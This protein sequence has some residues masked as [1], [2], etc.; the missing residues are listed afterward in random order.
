MSAPISRVVMPQLVV[1]AYSD[2]A[3]T[4][5]ELNARRLRKILP[6]KMR[7]AG[8]DGL[9]ILSHR[10]DAKR[11]EG[12]RKALAF[13]LLAADHGDRQKIAR[14]GFV[15]AQHFHGFL[16]G[17]HFRLVRRVAFLPEKL[18]RAKKEPRPQLPANDVRPLV[19]QDRQVAPGLH[20]SGVGRPD[21]RFRCRANN[22]RFAKGAGR[23]ELA[24]LRLQTV[25]RHHCTFL[26]KSLDMRG[27]L[28]Q[29]AQ[30]NEKRE[31][32]VAVAG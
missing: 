32:G 4:G 22:Q 1:Q 14:E 20:P 12:A 15:D 10:F 5:L 3:R 31:V 25:M 17:F 8:L 13:G 2:R 28:L 23:D 24:A 30:R 6:K 27:L 18:R 7:G 26:G 19:E 9:S 11:L 29:V 21:D 16:P